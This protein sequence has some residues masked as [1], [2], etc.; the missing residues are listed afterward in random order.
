MTLFPQ[1]NAAIEYTRKRLG[2]AACKVSWICDDIT[3]TKQLK[4]Y[5]VWHDRAV[6]HFLTNSS[7]RQAYLDLLNESLSSGGYFIV[8]TFAPDGPDKC[9]G[10]PICRYSLEELEATLGSS[11]RVVTSSQ[12]THLTPTGKT[13]RFTLAAFQKV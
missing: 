8:A 2:D 11:F 12:H 13:Q 6:F 4:K 9:S 5:D 7:D 1:H 3:K 10:L